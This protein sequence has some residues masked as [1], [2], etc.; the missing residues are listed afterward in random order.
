MA[1]R[2]VCLCNFIDEKEIC[3]LLKKGAESTSD[4]QMISRAGTSCGRCLPE[5]DEIVLTHNN[6]KPKPQQGK[7]KLGF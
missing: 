1:N 5:I 3:S 4:I 2:L 7:L 6:K